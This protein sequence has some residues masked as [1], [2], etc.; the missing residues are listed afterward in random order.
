M[1]LFTKEIKKIMPS[2][3]TNAHNGL[4]E[5][6]LYCKLFTPWSFWTWYIAEAN[7]ETGEAFGYVEGFEKEC[8]Y[9]DL[10]E[11]QSIKGPFGLKIERDIHFQPIL[12]KDLRK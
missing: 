4:D 2:I 1:L 8:G 9:F 6:K 3:G 7:F 12:Y 10:N 5:L 11:L